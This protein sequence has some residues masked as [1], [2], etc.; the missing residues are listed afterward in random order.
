[1]TAQVLNPLAAFDI[2][3]ESV[4]PVDQDWPEMAPGAGYRWLHLDINDPATAT[5]VNEHLPDVAANALLQAETRPRCDL[6][7]DGL[8]L[9]LR[10]V[11]L[12]PGSAPED[13]VSLRMW[14]TPHTIVSARVRKVW[15]ADALRTDAVEG[16]APR[17]I[18]QFLA[19]LT[20]SLTNRIEAVSLELEENTDELEEISAHG[21]SLSMD[22]LGNLRQ[23]VIKMR[24]F[25]NPQREAISNLANLDTTMIDANELTL[26]HETNNRTRRIVEELDAT[27]D[28]LSALQEHLDAERNQ[29]LGRNS[30]ILSVVAAIFLPLGF[31]TGLFGVNVGGMPGLNSDLAFTILS[32]ISVLCGVAL[33][34][35]FK[36]AKWL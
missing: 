9:N 2:D 26:L 8:I 35:I 18:G 22:S 33:Y 1:M 30:Y 4:T 5:W 3:A 10:G 13:M 24:R 17:T 25:I 11:N 19:A 31:L 36:F 34:L 23:T 6:L 28:R 27:R 32:V 20:H 16:K 7:P 15:A 14:V 29:A 21:R 12:N